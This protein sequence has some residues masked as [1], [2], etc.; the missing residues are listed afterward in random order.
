MKAF[1]VNTQEQYYY[2]DISSG[3]YPAALKQLDVNMPDWRNDVL[4]VLNKI[5]I[6]EAMKKEF[7]D[8]MANIRKNGLDAAVAEMQDYYDKMH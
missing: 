6:G 2:N 8:L 7:T 4:Q 1:E 3:Y 5:I